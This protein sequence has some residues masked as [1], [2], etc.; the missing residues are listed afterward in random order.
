MSA[1]SKKSLTW[2]I[3]LLILGV[4]TLCTGTT[5]LGVLVPAAALVWYGARPLL[6]SGRN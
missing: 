1:Q 5:W 6:R 2:T 4:T 3:V